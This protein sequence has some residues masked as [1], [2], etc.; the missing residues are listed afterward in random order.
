MKKVIFIGVVSMLFMACNQGTPRYTTTG[1]E[2]ELVKSLVADYEKG[3]WD[4]WLSHYAN[5]AQIHHNTWE[6]AY[7]SPKELKENLLSLLATTSSYGFDD[8]PIYYE[9]IIDD[10]GKTWVNFWGNW[11]GT[12][13]ENNKELQVPVHLSVHVADGKIHEEYAMYDLSEFTA[14]IQK[15]EAMKNLSPEENKSIVNNMYKSFSTGDI[16]AVLEALDPKVVWNE[17]E[18]NPWADGNPYIGPDAVLNGVFSRV[19]E[20]YEYFTLEDINLHDVGED[21]VLA[22]LRYNAE[23]KDNGA[24]LDVQAAHLWTIKNGKA[25]AFQQYADT[26]QLYETTNQ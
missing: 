15:I 3:D 22:T 5:T 19:G 14:E 20:E 26:K 18:G 12:L 10:E 1:P 17:A 25:T 11:R 6:D 8:T 2:V 4:A 7:I 23:R 9:K 21:K 16:P 24:K 13:G